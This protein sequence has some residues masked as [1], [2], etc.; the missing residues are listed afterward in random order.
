MRPNGSWL[1][2]PIQ[3][4]R[5]ASPHAPYPCC[6]TNLRTWTLLLAV[7]EGDEVVPVRSRAEVDERLAHLG[8]L[9]EEVPLQLLRTHAWLLV[10]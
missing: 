1:V 3:T 4:Q 10:L 9:V 6:T 7:L 5:E 2:N 8:E